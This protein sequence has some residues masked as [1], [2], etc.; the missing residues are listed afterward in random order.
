MEDKLKKQVEDAVNAI[1]ASKEENTNRQKA[2]DALQ[3]SADTIQDL[4]SQVE[5]ATEATGAVE[6]KVVE[7]ETQVETAT[8]EKAEMVEQHEVALKEATDAKEAADVELEKV[9]LELSTMKKE[10]T[11][12]KRMAELGTAGVVREATDVQR[13]KVMEMTDEE[14]AAYSEEL[15]S[16]KAQV[17]ESLKGKEDA[18]ADVDADADDAIDT[19][20]ANVDP[21]KTAQAALNL[22]S[23]PSQD[24]ASKYVDLGKAMAAAV[25]NK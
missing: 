24:M 2:E 17:I 13:A 25:T 18:T 15:V 21:E 22:E 14:F 16:I 9:T 6:A 4:T 3:A 23:Q 5:V 1:F 12:D 20:P 10:I 7:L 8:A 11:A 19:P